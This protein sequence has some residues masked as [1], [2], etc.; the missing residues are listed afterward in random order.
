MPIRIPHIVAVSSLQ[1][2]VS[3]LTR[4]FVVDTPRQDFFQSAL[5]RDFHFQ[6]FVP[7][8]TFEVGRGSPKCSMCFFTVE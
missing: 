1:W 2:R 4:S 8:V 7:G 6:T 3:A 5:Q